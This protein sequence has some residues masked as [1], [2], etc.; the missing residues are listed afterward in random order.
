MYCPFC[1][2]VDTKVI[3]S[4]LV[5][6]GTQVRRRRECQVCR[7]RFT[8]FESIEI[9]MPY[10]I[11]N[12]KTREIFDEEKL[13]KGMKKALKKRPV[14]LDVIKQSVISIKNQLRA[15]SESIV[16]SKF[17]GNLVMNELKKIDKIAYI[18]FASVYRSFDDICEFGKEIAKL[19]YDVSD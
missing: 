1:L 7:E 12:N 19:E 17:I 2:A 8:T 11:K 6:V 10:I 5:D 16:L 9:S 18:R 15:T 3:D 14:N 4:R 13:I